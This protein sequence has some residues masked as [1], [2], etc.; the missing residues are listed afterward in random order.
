MRNNPD[1]IT[2]RAIY[3]NG[4]FRPLEPLDLPENTLVELN[5]RIIEDQQT[6]ATL[7]PDGLDKVYE[8]LGRRHNS[9]RTDTSARHNEHQP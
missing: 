7:M 4:A 8:I 6:A 3:E 2:M 5:V 1:F 9:G